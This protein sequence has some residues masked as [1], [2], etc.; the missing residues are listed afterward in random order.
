MDTRGYQM[1]DLEG[2]EFQWQDLDLNMGAI[3][4]P[5]KDTPFCPSN[6]SD[7]EMG[8]MAENPTLVDEGQDKKNSP[9]P[10]PTHPTTPVSERLTQPAVLM[11]SRPF[12]TRNEHVPDYVDNLSEFFLFWLL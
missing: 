6:F 11:E 8:S 12:G 3:F 1:T 2:I 7:F 9:R 10:P 5:G 4:R